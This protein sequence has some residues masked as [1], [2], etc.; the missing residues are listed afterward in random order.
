MALNS[1]Q[2]REEGAFFMIHLPNLLTL[3]S[4][5]RVSCSHRQLATYLILSTLSDPQSLSALAACRRRCCV[6]LRPNSSTRLLEDLHIQDHYRFFSVPQSTRLTSPHA[7]SEPPCHA[8]PYDISYS[9]VS[10][11]QSAAVVPRLTK[12]ERLLLSTAGGE[13]ALG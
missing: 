12:T 2:G 9:Q 5:P 7:C 11:L 8:S 3:L 4:F 1:L 10:M 6:V 13:L